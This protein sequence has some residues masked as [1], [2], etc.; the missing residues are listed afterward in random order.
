MAYYMPYQS[1]KMKAF[2]HHD[3]LKHYLAI[4]NNAMAIRIKIL[5]L[6]QDVPLGDLYQC[7]IKEFPELE[8]YLQGFIRRRVSHHCTEGS[9]LILTAML[10]LNE[11][12]KASLWNKYQNS[13]EEK[14]KYDNMTLGEY[15]ESLRANSPNLISRPSKSQFGKT[16]ARERQ[17]SE[18]AAG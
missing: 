11:A 14:E 6:E 5:W 2:Q 3:L 16:V 15:H 4:I 18:R 7:M 1:I 8:V 9:T 12:D 10:F 13:F 17:N